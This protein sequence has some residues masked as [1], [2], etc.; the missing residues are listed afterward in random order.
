[1]FWVSE[2]IQD[3]LLQDNSALQKPD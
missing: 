2:L 1:M 3:N